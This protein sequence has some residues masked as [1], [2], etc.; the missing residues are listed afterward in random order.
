MI[1]VAANGDWQQY[2]ITGPGQ[3]APYPGVYST[4]VE[5]EDGSF[6]QTACR[7]NRR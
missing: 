3:F 4:L 5:N 6:T 7:T 2:A 1:V